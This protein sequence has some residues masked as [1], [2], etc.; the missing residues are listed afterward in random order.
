MSRTPLPA[1][2]SSLEQ[3]TRLPD[4]VVAVDGGSADGTSKLLRSYRGPLPLLVEELPGS[5]ISQGR[6]AAIRRATGE[7]IASTDAGVR[8]DPLWLA[9]LVRPLERE[10]GVEAVA[11]FFHPDPRSAFETALGATV[12]PAEEDVQPETFLPSSRS[13]AFTRAVWERAGGY[14]EWLD[15]CEDLVFDLRLREQGVRFHWAPRAV[16]RFRPRASLRAFFRQYYLYAR[17]DGKSD[18]WLKRHLC[19]YGVYAFAVLA[20]PLGIR[21]PLLWTGLVLGGAAYVY[22]PYRRLLPRLGGLPL[23]ERL[24]ALGCVPLVRLTGDVAKMLGYPAGVRW[25]WRHAAG[26]DRTSPP[27]PLSA[28]ERG[29]PPGRG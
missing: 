9:E 1:L 16:A 5:T 3:Q 20:L 11:G 22:N 4:E 10:P 25:R 14:P 2:L 21:A 8:L 24:I 28:S 15:Y 27:S 6:N 7:I 29:K 19:R 18:L 13:F 23:R 12:L 17:G 26:R